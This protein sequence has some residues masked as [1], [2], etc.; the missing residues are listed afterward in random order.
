MLKKRIF[1]LITAVA[2]LGSVLVGC[3]SEKKEVETT[4]STSVQAS[5]ETSASPKR[6]VKMYT[7]NDGTYGPYNIPSYDEDN[8]Y[9]QKLKEAY[10]SDAYPG[11]YIA[12]VDKGWIWYWE[13][14]TDDGNDYYVGS[15]DNPNYLQG[16]DLNRFLMDVKINLNQFIEKCDA[17]ELHPIDL[18]GDGSISYPEAYIQ[19][20]FAIKSNQ[21]RPY[22]GLITFFDFDDILWE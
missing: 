15:V 17:G 11:V 19:S 20:F 4:A 16:D 2:M 13:P 1:V 8:Q 5:A 18:D 22:N 21:D 12:R 10:A 3:G 6:E 14:E 7:Y 9:A